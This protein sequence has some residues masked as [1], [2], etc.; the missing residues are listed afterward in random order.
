MTLELKAKGFFE[1]SVTTC[2][3][4]DLTSHTNYS[5]TPMQE[6]KML[7]ERNFNDYSKSANPKQCVACILLCLCRSSKEKLVATTGATP[8]F[9]VDIFV[10]RE[11]LRPFPPH[12][13]AA[14][15]RLKHLFCLDTLMCFAVAGCYRGRPCCS[16]FSCY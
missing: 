13:F 11:F 14:P 8:V 15:Q 12:R 9:S 7:H 2:C 16:N 6:P 3:R 10:S 4:H 1:L 5:P